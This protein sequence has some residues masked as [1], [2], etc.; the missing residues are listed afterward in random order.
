MR[1]GIRDRLRVVA[2][3]VG[4]RDAV[5]LQDAGRGFG[6]DLAGGERVL[7]MAEEP[8]RRP[9]GDTLGH[10]RIGRP[11]DGAGH[12]R[13]H[14]RLADRDRA[15]IPQRA[16]RAPPPVPRRRVPRQVGRQRA[17]RQQCWLLA[18]PR[19]TGSA[20][21][22]DRAGPHRWCRLEG[23]RLPRNLA[24]PAGPKTPS[25]TSTM[26]WTISRVGSLMPVA[27]CSRREPGSVTMRVTA[28]A[29]RS[30]RLPA[31]PPPRAIWHRQRVA[32]KLYPR[33]LMGSPL[34]VPLP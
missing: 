4:R 17:P 29:R 19:T 27:D 24:T 26:P 5:A 6:R 31:E 1:H 11:G 18:C 30:S 2:G 34:M 20:P 22:L 7:H 33:T 14:A 23:A 13:G 16:G 3:E 9:G 8:L 21:Q 32:G 15:D 25:A 28:V 10:R 12:R